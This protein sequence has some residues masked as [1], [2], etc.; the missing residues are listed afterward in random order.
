MNTHPCQPCVKRKV[1]CDR[2]Q[3]CSNCKRRRKDVCTYVEASPWARIKQLEAL[4]RKLGGKPDRDGEV[5]QSPSPMQTSARDSSNSHAP[6]G[7]KWQ[8]NDPALAEEDG[9]NVYLES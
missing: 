3:P 4:V 5:D 6:R 7:G 8:G 1:R 9:A 2:Q